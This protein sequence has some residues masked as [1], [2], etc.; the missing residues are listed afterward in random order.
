[1]LRLISTLLIVLFYMTM[2]NAEI[3]KSIEIKNNFRVSKQTIINFGKVELG[4]DYSENDLNIILKNLY[5]TNFFSDISI[6]VKNNV[7][8][9]DVKENKIIQTLKIRGLKTKSLNKTLLKEVS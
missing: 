1:M 2:V 7:L 3:I 6:S 5:N 4:K 8:V 9:I